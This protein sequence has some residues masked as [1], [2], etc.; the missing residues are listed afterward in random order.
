MINISAEQRLSEILESQHELKEQSEEL[1]HLMA[2][3]EQ[4]ESLIKDIDRVSAKL[5]DAPLKGPQRQ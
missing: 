3:E 4:Y 5:N 1:K 2:I